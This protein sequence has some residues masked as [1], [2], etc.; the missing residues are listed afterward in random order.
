MGRSILVAGGTGLVGSHLLQQLSTSADS[1]EITALVRKG[2]TIQLPNVKSVEVDYDHF[3]KI[4]EQLT[5]DIAFCCLGTT[6][7]QAGSKAAFK[8][9]DYTYP[10]ELAK[11][12]FSKNCSQFHI[13]TATGADAKSMVF[14][15]RV[16]GEVEG[17]LMQ[18]G[19]QSLS[20]YRPSLLLGERK[21]KRAGEFIAAAISSIINPALIGRFRK[22]RAI[23][24]EVVARA[25]LQQAEAHQA[26]I[27][28]LES[29]KIQELGQRA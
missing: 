14:Y 25:M 11:L 20:I 23:R 26:G 22:Y 12:L 17:E 27:H 13:V 5:A 1:N 4:D 15:N 28:I 7:K 8:K 29:N 19:F 9:V 2:R 10:L 18:I 3:N 24:A 21:E 6:I 16:K